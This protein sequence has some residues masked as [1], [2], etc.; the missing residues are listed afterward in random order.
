MAS[1]AKL[2]AVSMIDPKKK[3]REIMESPAKLAL[4]LNGKFYP[5]F[6]EN[7]GYSQEALTA[8]QETVRTLLD[9]PTSADRPG[10]LSVRF[11]AARL[12]LSWEQ[13][14]LR[15]TMALTCALY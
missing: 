3:D 9:K 1:L 4:K 5:K 8:I 11:R 2:W 12:R 13:S 6:V 7:K 14:R 15:S 10:M